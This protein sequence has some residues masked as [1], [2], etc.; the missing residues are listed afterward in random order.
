M[1]EAATSFRTAASLYQ[2]LVVERARRPL[3]AGDLDPADGAGDGSNPLCGD[4]VRVSVR[5]DA[6]R[7]VAEIA[8]RTRGCAIC[9]ASADLMADSVVGLDELRVEAL[10]GRLDHLMQQGADAVG[11]DGREQLGLLLAFSDLHDYRSRRKC[12]TLP[13]SALRAAFKSAEE[14]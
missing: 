13:W 3:H 4:K 6:H 9:A 5:L 10:Y 12:A 7:Q 2:E 8:H 14:P 1:S 11:A